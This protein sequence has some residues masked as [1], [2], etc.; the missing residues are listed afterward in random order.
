MYPDSKSSELGQALTK[1]LV[2]DTQAPFDCTVAGSGH[3]ER[4]LQ[5]PVAPNS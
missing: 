1:F 2:V 4:V 5:T 3:G